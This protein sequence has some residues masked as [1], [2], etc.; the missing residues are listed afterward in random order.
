LPQRCGSLSRPPQPADLII[1]D[2]AMPGWLV[3]G[4]Q[5]IPRDPVLTHIPVLFQPPDQGRTITGFFRA[6]DYL[7]KP[8]NI[9]D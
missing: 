7:C 2:V 1:L 5:E 9:D 6:D 8:F 4:C 3:C